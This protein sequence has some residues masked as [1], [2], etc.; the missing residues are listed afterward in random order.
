MENLK[1]MPSKFKLSKDVGDT[2]AASINANN[3]LGNT[4]PGHE[5]CIIEI[6]ECDT[7]ASL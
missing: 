5:D 7:S 6:L 4:V 1:L 3:D 2:E